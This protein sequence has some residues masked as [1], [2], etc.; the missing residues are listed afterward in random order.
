MARSDDDNDDDDDDD[1][2]D[3][4]DNNAEKTTTKRPILRDL[5]REE[6]QQYDEDND[7]NNDNE[8][9]DIGESRVYKAFIKLGTGI[10]VKYHDT[11][12]DRDYQGDKNDL[13]SEIKERHSRRFRDATYI[14]PVE[15]ITNEFDTQQAKYDN[16]HKEGFEEMLSKETR[17]SRNAITDVIEFD[18]TSSLHWIRW[19]ALEDGN[20]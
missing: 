10:S 6:Q 17:Y 3:D 19:L 13:I 14:D 5:D 18:H 2:D 4:G 16:D 9:F 7:N 11:I 1:N 8:N 15:E 20:V 12:Y